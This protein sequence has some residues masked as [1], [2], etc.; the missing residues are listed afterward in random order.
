MRSEALTSE[1]KDCANVCIAKEKDGVGSICYLE[2]QGFAMPLIA[3][4]RASSLVIYHER[5]HY[6]RQ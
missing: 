5:H 6:K 4:R 1:S 3:L 2:R